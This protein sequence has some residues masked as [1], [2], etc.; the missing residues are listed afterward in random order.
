MAEVHI[1]I[2]YYDLDCLKVINTQGILKSY[3]IFLG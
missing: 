3:I 1:Y 2:V